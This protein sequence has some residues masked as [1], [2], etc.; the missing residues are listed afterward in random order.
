M[1]RAGWDGSEEE[2]ESGKALSKG[3][4]N[5]NLG[6]EG[7]GFVREAGGQNLASREGVLWTR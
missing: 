5:I 6:L 4:A 2:R 3:T 1:I 7:A